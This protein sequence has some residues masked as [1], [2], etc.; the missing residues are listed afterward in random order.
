MAKLSGTRKGLAIA[1]L[2][3]IIDGI[4]LT[5]A[6]LE[7]RPPSDVTTTGITTLVL[8][9]AGLILAVA[10]LVLLFRRP[11]RSSIASTVAAILGVPAFL[12]DQ[13]GLLSIMRPS[14]VINLLEFVETLV[15]VAIIVLAARNSMEKQASGPA[16]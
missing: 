3:Y 9:I 7:T 2:V 13:A 5:P 12:A 4:L 8:F 1:L 14:S 11:R 6:G 16:S 15:A 10:S